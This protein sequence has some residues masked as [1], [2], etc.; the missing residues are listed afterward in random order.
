MGTIKNPD[1]YINYYDKDTESWIALEDY[2]VGFEVRDA[3]V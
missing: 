1:I 2:A 3:S